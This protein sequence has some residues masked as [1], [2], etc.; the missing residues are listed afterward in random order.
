[1]SGSRSQRTLLVEI[2]IAVLFFALCATVLLQTFA[3]AHDYSHRAGADGAALL[4]AQ[5]LAECLIAASDA[6]AELEA[7]GF[8]R[9]DGLWRREDE[10]WTLEVE[11]NEESAPAGTLWTARIRALRGE[12]V[13]VDL[14]CAR[15]LPGEDDL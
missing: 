3:T 15:Y 13:I 1:M 2:M 10:S 12:T 4:E 5:D 7:R 6:Q 14:P 8:A 9:E 11:P